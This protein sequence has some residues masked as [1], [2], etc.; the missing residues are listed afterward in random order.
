MKTENAE[1]TKMARESLKGK[2][3]LAVGTFFLYMLILGV[4]NAIPGIGSVAVLIIS[5]PMMLG[6]AIFVLSISRGQEAKLEQIFMGF[7]KFGTTLGAYLLMVLFILL[8]SLLLIVPGIIAAYSYSMTFF[9]LADDN[10]NIGAMDA[11]NKSKGMMMGHKGKLFCLSLRFIGWALLCLLTAGIGYFWL[12]P[13]MEVSFAKFYEDIKND[14]VTE[15]K[16]PDS[17]E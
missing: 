3:W 7:Q 15:I 17:V 4:P 1:L 11:L 16:S 10:E 9:I 14:Y 13:Y 6:I 8:W 5:G 2:W 12:A